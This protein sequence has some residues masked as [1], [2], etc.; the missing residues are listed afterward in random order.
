MSSTFYLGCLVGGFSELTLFLLNPEGESRPGKAHR[1]FLFLLLGVQVRQQW[2]P[3]PGQALGLQLHH[4]FR[5]GQ[6]WQGDT[7]Q[8]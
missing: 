3:G 4:G 7:R 8:T 1:L 5:K 2:Q 6:F